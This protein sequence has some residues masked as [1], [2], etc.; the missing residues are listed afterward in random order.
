MWHFVIVP[1][2]SFR[3]FNEIR[4][5]SVP[6]HIRNGQVEEY[7]AKPRIYT[8][9]PK[10]LLISDLEQRL[11]DG[12]APITESYIVALIA[13]MRTEILED[14]GNI[15]AQVAL[16]R[17]Y[18]LSDPTAAE[19]VFQRVVLEAPNK[20]HSY[21]YLGFAQRLSGQ[22]S[23]AAASFRRCLDIDTKLIECDRLLRLSE[24]RGD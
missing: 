15:K 12:H 11:Q 24:R 10:L 18:L 1:Y 22:A 20:P 8:L 3:E 5:D 2:D 13:S 17:L 6:A 14:P 7:F 19:A 23:A 21:Y 9:W 16:G 4:F